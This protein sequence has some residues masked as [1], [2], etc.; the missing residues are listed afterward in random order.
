MSCVPEF[1]PENIKLSESFRPIEISFNDS[2]KVRQRNQKPLARLIVVELKKD[3]CKRHDR[4]LGVN[5]ERVRFNRLLLKASCGEFNLYLPVFSKP[6]QK[7]INKACNRSRRP[8][9]PI[10]IDFDRNLGV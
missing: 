7:M 2:L 9:L 3:A 1:V 6:E 4:Q 10:L 8:H 5:C